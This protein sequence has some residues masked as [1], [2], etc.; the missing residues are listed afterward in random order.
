[1]GEVLQ[2]DYLYSGDPGNRDF[3]VGADPYTQNTR[4]FGHLGLLTQ[5]LECGY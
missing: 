2:V 1:M 4:N 3:S 5:M